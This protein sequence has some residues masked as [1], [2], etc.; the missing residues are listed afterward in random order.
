MFVGYLTLFMCSISSNQ[1]VPVCCQ[2][3]W[4]SS[5][6]L[7]KVRLKENRVCVELN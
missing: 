6:L 1:D 2:R 7:F 3:A 5:M 4:L